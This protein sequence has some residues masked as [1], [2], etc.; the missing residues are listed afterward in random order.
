M[1]TFSSGTLTLQYTELGPTDGETA[2]LLHG[3]P[4]DSTSWAQVGS[5]LAEAG[6]HVLIPD[7]RGYSPQ[8]QPARLAEYTVAALVGDVVALLDANG[9]ESAHVIGHDWGGSLVWTMR[10]TYAHRIITAT[11][12]STPHPAALS[13]AWT[14]TGQLVRSWYMGAVALPVLPEIVIKRRLATLLKASD[15]PADR[16]SYYQDLMNR[17][18][19]TT[20]ALNWYR[21]MLRDLV[22][23]TT[24]AKDAKPSPPPPTLY[25]W[26]TNDA[27]FNRAVAR[28]TPEVVRDLKFQEIE[29]GSHWLPETHPHE[30]ADS[31]SQ[32]M[33]HR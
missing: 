31:I 9:V 6:Y 13:W 19:V 15:L 27:F 4:Q 7:L 22:K 14:H 5:I 23:P 21:Q 17:P 16:A 24:A 10:K 29:S 30:L 28:K 2:V 11:V 20:G 12:V 26:G 8:A 25:L 1:Q 18:G 3:F 33:R 32:H